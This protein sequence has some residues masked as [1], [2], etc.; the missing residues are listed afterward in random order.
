MKSSNPRKLQELIDIFMARVYWD[1][2]DEE[3][4]ERH[5]DGR[6]LA[7]YIESSKELITLTGGEEEKLLTTALMFVTGRLPKD[8]TDL[9]VN[10]FLYKEGDTLTLYEPEEDFKFG[11]SGYAMYEYKA[12]NTVNGKSVQD[13]FAVFMYS[14]EDTLETTIES[15]EDVKETFEI[16]PAVEMPEKTHIFVEKEEYKEEPEL[17]LTKYIDS[18]DNSISVIDAVPEKIVHS[19][20][21]GKT[22]GDYTKDKIKAKTIDQKIKDIE[23]AVMEVD[24]KN[25]Y[26]GDIDLTVY[27]SRTNPLAVVGK[28]EV[29][30]VIS[31]LVENLGGES[32]KDLNHI[33]GVFIVQD[34]DSY[35]VYKEPPNLFVDYKK[36]NEE[37]FPV[38]VPLYGADR[39]GVNF[40]LVEYSAKGYKED[41]GNSM[42]E[43]AKKAKRESKVVASENAVVKSEVENSKENTTNTEVPI[44][45]RPNGREPRFKRSSIFT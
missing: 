22:K 36:Y 41:L 33:P 13:S 27:V 45:L 12:T 9:A 42:V 20:I 5:R 15:L 6:T 28:E 44:K 16:I 32:I 19:L 11:V 43:L 8:E 4:I 17:E 18:S 21:G 31:G 40:N 14:Y 26:E 39:I 29:S 38:E 35:E 25:N 2:Y 34:G 10:V 24:N 1:D 3:L 7:D 37:M 23:R 30:K